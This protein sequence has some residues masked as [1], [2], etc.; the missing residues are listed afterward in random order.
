[1][2]IVEAPAEVP[3][4]YPAGHRDGLDAAALA[5]FQ[6]LAVTPAPEVAE[7]MRAEFEAYV[8]RIDPT[9]SDDAALAARWLATLPPVYA[10][11]V[12]VRGPAEIARIAREAIGRTSGYSRDVAVSF[13][14]WEFDPSEIRCPIFAWYGDGDD[15]CS[16]RNGEWFAEALGATYAR[17]A[18]TSHLGTLMKHWPD[19]LQ[20]PGRPQAWPRVP[21]DR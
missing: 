10:T 3:S 9:D 6:S 19:I 16:P 21:K 1:M 20:D 14:A 11:S 15:T 18:G 8:A 13:R 12:A 4:L 7:Q 17:V 2:G 5:F